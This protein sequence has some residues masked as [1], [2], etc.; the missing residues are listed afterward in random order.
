MSNDLAKHSRGR[1][2]RRLQ[3]IGPKVGCQTA[4]ATAEA[5]YHRLGVRSLQSSRLCKGCHLR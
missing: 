5:L 3:S 4:D 2:L 1:F